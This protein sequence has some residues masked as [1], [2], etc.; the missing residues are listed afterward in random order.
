MFVN[1][2]TGPVSE[3]DQ[4]KCI[5][6][7]ES[8]KEY[9]YSQLGK[10]PIIVPA[11]P[12]MYSLQT[13]SA[14]DVITK[15]GIFGRDRMEE[16]LWREWPALFGDGGGDTVI[17]FYQGNYGATAATWKPDGGS[18]IL[19]GLLAGNANISEKLLVFGLAHEMV[20][21]LGVP[22]NDEDR[23]DLM[24]A[25]Q[26]QWAVYDDQQVVLDIHKI[27]YYDTVRNSPFMA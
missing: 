12:L 26:E 6:A 27:G 18:I 11:S 3:S 19:Y 16:F 22:H 7:L 24:Y 9:F 13:P 2:P 14:L 4:R 17:V 21:S 23:H 20:H 5:A 15:D 25:G 10:R 8:T 1:G